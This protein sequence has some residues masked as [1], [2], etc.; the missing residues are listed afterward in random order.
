MLS[1]FFGF[2]CAR[3]LE[4]GEGEGRREK[5]GGVLFFWGFVFFQVEPEQKKN[6]IKN[7]PVLKNPH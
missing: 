2:E 5:R 4:G 1:F 3:L 7:P 6:V